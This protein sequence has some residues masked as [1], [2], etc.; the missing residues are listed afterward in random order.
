MLVADAT[1]GHDGYG[2]TAAASKGEDVVRVRNEE[3][4]AHAHIWADWSVAKRTQD[5]SGRCTHRWG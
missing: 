5:Q 1:V 3:G 4:G 2:G